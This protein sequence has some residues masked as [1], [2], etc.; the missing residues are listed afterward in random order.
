MD[1]IK[2]S[3]PRIVFL[4]TDATDN[5]TGETG[6]TPTITLSKNGGT[7]TAATNSATEISNGWYY[8]DLTATETNTDGPMI[9]E[10][11]GSGSNVWRQI[12]NVKTYALHVT[13]LVKLADIVLRRRGANVEQS[14]FGDTLALDSLY[15]LVQSTNECALSGGTLTVKQTDGST[16]L[17][18]IGVTT[19]SGTWTGKTVN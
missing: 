4:L 1:I 13:E 8:V 11:T 18:T 14:S 7:L 17:G 5:E 3:T 2:G 9:F 15:G 16:T 19:S 6:I 12:Y 10:A